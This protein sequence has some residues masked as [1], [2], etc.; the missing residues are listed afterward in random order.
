MAGLTR[1]QVVQYNKKVEDLKAS[2]AQEKAKKEYAEQELARLCAE[3]SEHFGREI[4]PD[5][6]EAEYAA[7]ESEA[8]TI[9][10]SGTRIM[11]SAAREAREA[12]IA[13]TDVTAAP[14]AP[15]FDQALSS[16]PVSVPKP[17]GVELDELFGIL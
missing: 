5:T 16:N 17:A 9:I 2:A 13:S 3:L 10:E 6:L 4:T 8:L 14:P 11:E 12:E 1:Q 15:A 7:F